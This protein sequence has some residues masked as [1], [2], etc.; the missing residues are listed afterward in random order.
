MISTTTRLS[1]DYE[2][3][4]RL[5]FCRG[6]LSSGVGPGS[7]VGLAT[8]ISEVESSVTTWEHVDSIS[9]KYHRCVNTW[10]ERTR[11]MISE[12]EAETLKVRALRSI[13]MSC[14]TFA[15]SRR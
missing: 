8:I 3:W 13:D 12:E 5:S 4:I 7:I 14:V 10:L 6:H 2:G 1:F 9:V 11:G 15:V